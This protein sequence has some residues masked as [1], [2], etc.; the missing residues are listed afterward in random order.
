MLMWI[1]D[2]WNGP[3]CIR[4]ECVELTAFWEKEKSARDWL[5]TL[6][7]SC[8]TEALRLPITLRTRE[9]IYLYQ[10]NN[11]TLFCLQKL[12]REL[13][14]QVLTF[15]WTCSVIM[16]TFGSLS[17]TCLQFQWVSGSYSCIYIHTGST[18]ALIQSSKV[19]TAQYV[20][21]RWCWRP[22]PLFRDSCTNLM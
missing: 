14:V 11:S 19:K 22:F 2:F 9:S 1:I 20:E 21:N 7:Y 17:K 10:R 8:R 15:N 6:M 5:I 13:S 3:D 18:N 4:C 16:K 12:I